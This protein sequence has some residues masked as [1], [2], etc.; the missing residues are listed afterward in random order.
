MG[1]IIISEICN[2]IVHEIV[3]LTHL[4]GHETSVTFEFE[5]KWNKINKL[6][7]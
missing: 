7:N 1:T 5:R 2:C 3:I 6:D 4:G